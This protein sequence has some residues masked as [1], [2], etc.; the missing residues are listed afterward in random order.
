MPL[1]LVDE[2][3]VDLLWV[4]ASHRCEPHLIFFLSAAQHQARQQLQC[5]RFWLKRE[6]IRPL[7]WDKASGS[8]CSTTPATPSLHLL[9][10]SL[11]S[12]SSGTLT[13]DD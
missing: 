7:P 4:E 8:A 6:N 9:V 5:I 13:E 1:P 2:P 11:S 12:A 10:A 3:I